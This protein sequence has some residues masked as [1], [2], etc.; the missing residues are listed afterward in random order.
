MKLLKDIGEF[1]GFSAIIV[2]VVGFGLYFFLSFLAWLLH[3][4]L[5]IVDF[6]NSMY[7]T[8]RC[9]DQVDDD[10]EPCIGDDNILY[11]NG[12]DYRKSI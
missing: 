9:V 11:K 1:V 8:Q 10:S 2:L 5:D 12:Y 3:D 6:P 7:E 4:P